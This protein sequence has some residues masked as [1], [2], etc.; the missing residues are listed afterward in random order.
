MV[1]ESPNPFKAVAALFGLSHVDR[2]AFMR[3]DARGP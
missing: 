2:L 3:A 1:A